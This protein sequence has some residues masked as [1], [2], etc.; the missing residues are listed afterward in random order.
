MRSLS[1]S[2]ADR[3]AASPE[4][5]CRAAAAGG[6]H[7][8]PRRRRRQQV[9]LRSVCSVAYT[10]LHVAC[11]QEAASARYACA[12]AY[13]VRNVHM[14][15]QAA[16][17]RGQATHR[18][19]PGE[20]PRRDGA[21]ETQHAQASALLLAAAQAATHRSRGPP[22]CSGLSLWAREEGPRCL[23]AEER[24]R[25][26]S[27]AYPV[28]DPTAFGHIRKGEDALLASVEEWLQTTA[29]AAESAGT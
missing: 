22:A 3:D 14:H 15:M 9:T 23:E 12:C 27:G 10:P 16:S 6:C 25:L 8:Q 2:A 29:K 5:G 21:A 13:A 17:A 18:C 24:P 1:A 20:H 11:V 7:R 28:A 19:T 4:A 26:Y